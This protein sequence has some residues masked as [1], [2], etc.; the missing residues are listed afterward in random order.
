MECKDAFKDAFQNGYMCSVVYLKGLWWPSTLS[1]FRE[2]PSNL[3]SNSMRMF[4][5]DTKI[6]R[7]I[8]VVGDSLSL[9]ED[10]HK[11]IKWSNK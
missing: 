9:Q 10:L 2:L 5:D 7:G 8:Q 6:W 11:L 3:V 1:D 4:A